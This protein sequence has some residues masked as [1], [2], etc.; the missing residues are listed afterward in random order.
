MRVSI[1][2]PVLNVEPQLRQTIDRLFQLKGDP[3]LDL[4]IILVVDVPDP[5]REEE[6]M[7]ENDL[8]ASEMDAKA[9]YRIGKRGFGSA[10]R[11]GFDHATGEA[12]IPFM[13][14]ACDDPGDIPRLV[15]ALE[16]GWDVVAGSRYMRGG[17]IVGNTLK[18]RLSRLYGGLV[19]L[20]GGPDIRDVSNAFK[21]YRRR[22]VEQTP[23]VAE[24]F[25]VSVELT[26]RAHQAGF[27]ITEIPTVWINRDLGSSS[28]H[29]S[30]EL[31]RYSRWL[32][33]AL[34]GPAASRT[35]LAPRS[36]RR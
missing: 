28:W 16:D 24:S 27:R 14:D 21:A 8:I 17:R 32:W 12:M 7:R 9:V 6:S 2:I 19:R 18:Q 33:L 10:L 15:A 36:E 13:A 25:D 3:R 31:R 22:V 20:V 23:T 5:S 1:V 4:E 30:K 26:V 29:F 35:P 11:F 34:R